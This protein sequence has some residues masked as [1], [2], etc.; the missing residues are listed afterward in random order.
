M[1]FLS[2]A[3][4][5]VLISLTTFTKA[6]KDASGQQLTAQRFEGDGCDQVKNF[7]WRKCQ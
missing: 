3:I 1:I 7:A 6:N 4:C 2:Q 5:L